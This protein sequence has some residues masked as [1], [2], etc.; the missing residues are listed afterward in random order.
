MGVLALVVD[1]A[2]FDQDGL[3]SIELLIWFTGLDKFCGVC[4]PGTISTGE[5][6]FL[7]MSP[8]K[9]TNQIYEPQ[10]Q[11]DSLGS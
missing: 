2:S 8:E 1:Y 3:F 11:Y 4:P 7:R 6:D 10:R 9:L 5:Y